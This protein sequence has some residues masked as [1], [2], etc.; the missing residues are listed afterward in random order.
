ML[1]ENMQHNTNEAI[2]LTSH[3][4]I[5]TF[6]CEKIKVQGYFYHF[7]L[8]PRATK[9]SILATSSLGSSHLTKPKTA[10]YCSLT[11]VA[12]SYVSRP[13][14][15]IRGGDLGA[16]AVQCDINPPYGHR[17]SGARMVNVDVC[18]YFISNWSSNQH[19]ISNNPDHD[20]LEVSNYLLI[21]C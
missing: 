19:Q 14:Q 20:A 4:N 15:Q 2:T 17:I 1:V 3:D 13:Q 18:I 12:I 16:G 11:V 9:S 7:A 21:N 8:Q 6:K 5:R 10:Y